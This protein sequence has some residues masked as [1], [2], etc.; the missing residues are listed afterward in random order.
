MGSRVEM[1][2][3]VLILRIVAATDMSADETQAQVYPAITRFQAILA[4]SGARCD[5][6]YLVEM[7]T[8]LCHVFVLSL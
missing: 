6:T 4:P 2:G 7:A 3:S 8:V 5:F 1:L